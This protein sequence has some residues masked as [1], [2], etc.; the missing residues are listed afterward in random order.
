MDYIFDIDDT[1]SNSSHR[2]HLLHGPN[3]DW[4]LYY[5]LLV[6]DP[7][8][9]SSVAILKALDAAGH[10]I[11]LCTGRPERYRNLTIQWLQLHNIPANDLYMR[12]RSEEYLRNYQIKRILL[13]CIRS[14]GYYP[15]AVFEDNPLS[16]EMWKA[17]GLQVFQ[18]A[19]K[20]TP[21]TV[22]A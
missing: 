15:E 10:R 7:P 14:D 19:S 12:Q 17:V 21:S 13:D 2:D 1:L 6:E 5:N 3:K 18:V 9:A 8:I 20:E 22:N 4:E 16:V 11:I